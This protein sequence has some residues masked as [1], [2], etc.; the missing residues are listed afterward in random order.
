MCMSIAFSEDFF[1][2]MNSIELEE[3]YNGLG[4][5]SIHWVL[6]KL[7]ILLR[8]YGPDRILYGLIGHTRCNKQID[9]YNSVCGRGERDVSYAMIYVW[10]KYSPILAK[11]AVKKMFDIFDSECYGESEDIVRICRFLKNGV[12]DYSLD[13]QIVEEIIQFIVGNVNSSIKR[14]EP[15]YAKVIPREG[16]SNDWLFKKFVDDFY[17]GSSFHVGYCKSY[18]KLISHLTAEFPC[19]TLEYQQNCIG[20]YVKKAVEVVEGDF[21]TMAIEKAWKFVLY[22]ARGVSFKNILPIADISCFGSLDIPFSGLTHKFAHNMFDDA[23][24]N[25]IGYSIFA[26]VANGGCRRVFLMSHELHWVDLS[27]EECPTFC[28]CVRKIMKIIE[29]RT[30]RVGTNYATCSFVLR[31]TLSKLGKK[32]GEWASSDI[33]PCVFSAKYVPFG[34]WWNTG[35]GSRWLDD[36]YGAA[37]MSGTKPGLF[38]RWV[39]AGFQTPIVG[40]AEEQYLLVNYFDSIVQDSSADKDSFAD[41]MACE[42]VDIYGRSTAY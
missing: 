4:R 30:F 12:V 22:K 27:E 10:W 17:N 15:F 36:N 34:K 1:I 29:L 16:K 23:F 9:N 21:S 37:K 8:S 24:Y 11:H 6:N 20:W 19:N 28:D 26:A 18:R 13:A 7:D 5:H 42:F 41:N 35:S 33:V 40:F 2:V 39:S 14:G 25:N 31:H 3:F 38:V 32:D